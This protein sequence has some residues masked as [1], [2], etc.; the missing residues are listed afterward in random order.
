MAGE[1]FYPKGYIGSEQ[2]ILQIAK[3]RDPSRWTHERILPDERLVWDALGT[4]LNAQFIEGHLRLLMKDVRPKED[5]SRIDRLCDFSDALG[6]LRKSLF[7]GETV[8]YFCD[9]QGKLDFI[10]KEGWG[11]DEGS[12]I[13]LCGIVDVEGGLAPCHFAQNR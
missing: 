9:E 4:H 2:A 12:D 13:L 3:T 1:R 8:A 5:T 10:I 7:S 6:E 11:R